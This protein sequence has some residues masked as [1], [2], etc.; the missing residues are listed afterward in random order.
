MHLRRVVHGG[1]AASGA[2][3]PRFWYFSTPVLLPRRN[4]L[5]LGGRRDAHAAAQISQKPEMDLQPIGAALSRAQ[6]RAIPSFLAPRTTDALIIDTPIWSHIQ[7][8]EALAHKTEIHQLLEHSGSPAVQPDVVTQADIEDA[9]ATA[10]IE[11]TSRRR[12]K[13]TLRKSTAMRDLA[14]Q[15]WLQ[16]NEDDSADDALSEDSEKV[17]RFDWRGKAISRMPVH[18]RDQILKTRYKRTKP[19]IHPLGP[20]DIYDQAIQ[21]YREKFVSSIIPSPP[22]QISNQWPFV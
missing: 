7:E 13:P 2:K 22:A 5:H 17:G 1:S 15:P 6:L 10:E 19:P 11:S 16:D 14:E 12:R 4:G 8:A 18:E 20:Y 3:S 21:A 9:F